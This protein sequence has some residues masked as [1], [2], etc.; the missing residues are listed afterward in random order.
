[1]NALHEMCSII[2]TTNKSQKRWAETLDDEVVVTALLGRLLFKCEVVK[3]EWNSYR[4]VYGKNIFNNPSP[5]RKL[6]R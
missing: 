1:M 4:M 5:T 6:D 2:I 3:L